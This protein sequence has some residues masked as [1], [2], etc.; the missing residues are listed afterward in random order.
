VL[1]PYHFLAD[2]SGQAFAKREPAGIRNVTHVSGKLYTVPLAI[3][4]LGRSTT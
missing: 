4:G 1:A 2:L 3:S